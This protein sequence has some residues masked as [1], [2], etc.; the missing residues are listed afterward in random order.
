MNDSF[1]YVYLLTDVSSIT[2]TGLHDIDE[3][4]QAQLLLAVSFSA[5]T[6]SLL[7]VD[8]HM[9]VFYAILSVLGPLWCS[10]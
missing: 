1:F 4:I 2:V 5:A 10:S 6:T 8:C 3:Y 7:L 9:S